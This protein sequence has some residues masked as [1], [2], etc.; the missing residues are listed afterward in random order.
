MK[1]NEEILNVFKFGHLFYFRDGLL[2]F[3]D[4][5]GKN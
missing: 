4:N 3:K 5:D 2:Y 1:A